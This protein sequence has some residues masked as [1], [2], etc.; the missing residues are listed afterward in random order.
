MTVV[1]VLDGLASALQLDNAERDHL[2]ALARQSQASTTRRPPTPPTTVRPAVQQ[3]LDAITEA[4]AWIRNGRHDII[5]MNQL[6]RAL[7]SPV[8]AD[9]RRPASTTRFV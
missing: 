1:P 4:P 9:P 2:L 3:V 6:A 5:A 8:L 7:Y